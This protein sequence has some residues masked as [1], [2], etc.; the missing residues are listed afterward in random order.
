L[1]L[2]IP[3]AG[4]RLA[5]V[6]VKLD[7]FD[8]VLVQPFMPNRAVVALDLGVLMGLAGMDVEDGNSL[9]LSPFRQ[10]FI[11][12]FRAIIDQNAA[13]LAT[14]EKS[15]LSSCAAPFVQQSRNLQNL[16]VHRSV[17]STHHREFFIC[18]DNKS[19]ILDRHA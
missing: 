4:R 18:V 16:L 17:N 19:V 1:I 5:A 3:L 7:A 13:R 6:A 10:L 8:D 14:P 15:G 11:D 2:G 9:S 12:I